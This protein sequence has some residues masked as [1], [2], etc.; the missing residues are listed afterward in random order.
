[1]HFTIFEHIKNFKLSDNIY[2]Y[3]SSNFNNTHIFDEDMLEFIIW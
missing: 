1:M 2:N 3:F